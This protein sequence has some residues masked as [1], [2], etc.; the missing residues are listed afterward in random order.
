MRF[1]TDSLNVL[2]AK[3]TWSCNFLKIDRGLLAA[4]RELTDI[5]VLKSFQLF[6]NG[7]PH[8]GEL[9]IRGLAHGIEQYRA[10]M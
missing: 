4:L 8:C 2:S 10:K 1:A 5:L 9:L 7:A 3:E 6:F